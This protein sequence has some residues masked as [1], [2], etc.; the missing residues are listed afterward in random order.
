MEKRK[1]HEQAI[2]AAFDE[3]PEFHPRAL[4]EPYVSLSIHTAPDVRPLPWHSGQWAKSA[5]FARRSP[6]EPVPRALGPMDHP[7]VFA[8]GSSNDTGVDPF[9]GWTQ[10]R[11][12]EVAKEANRR[13]LA[14]AEQSLAALLVGEARA[15]AG[16]V[17]VHALA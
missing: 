4:P 17:I 11:R 1:L 5:G 12:I 8:A 6:I 3:S 15:V 9:Q 2:S 14:W 10:L 16:P 13:A 7:L